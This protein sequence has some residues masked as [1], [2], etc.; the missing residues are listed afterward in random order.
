MRIVELNPF[1]FP[2]MGGIEHRVHN[3][4]KRLAGNHEVFIL[5]GRLPGTPEKED[6][7]GYTVVRLESKLIDIYNPPYISSKG[8]GEALASLKPD[9]VDFHYRWA[10]SYTRAMKRY[11]GKRVFTFHNTFGEGV[12]ATRALSVINDRWQSGFIKGFDRIICVSDFVMEDLEARGF[13]A[14][15]M[16]SVPNGVDLPA[17]LAGEGPHMLFLGRLVATKGLDHLLGAAK[18]LSDKRVDFELVIAGGGPEERN[19]RKAVA[20]MGLE[21]KVKVTGRVSEEE[22]HRLLATC[23]FFVF[24]STFESYGIAAAEAMAYGKAVVASNA[25]GL[26]EVVRDAGTLVPPKDPAALARA[27]EEMLGDAGR[28]KALGKRAR[29]LAAGYAWDSVA[30]RMEN[31]YREVA[32]SRA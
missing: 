7:D 18:L 8:I 13:P 32:E 20:S 27:M 31:V 15:K 11:R 1:H 12:G 17:S 22:K 24:P 23:R 19:L 9:I 28:R 29:E 30:S 6:M 21:G 3:I 4:A 25:G 2:Y 26:P 5:T 14:S 16:V 10:P